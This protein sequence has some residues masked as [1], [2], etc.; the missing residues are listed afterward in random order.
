MTVSCKQFTAIT[1]W[2]IGRPRLRGDGLPTSNLDL[3]NDGG[4]AFT[5]EKRAGS[6]HARRCHSSASH[7]QTS[8]VES[9][10]SPHSGQPGSSINPASKRRTADQRP[11]PTKLRKQDASK[12]GSDLITDAMGFKKGSVGKLGLFAPASLHSASSASLLASH[13]I[14]VGHAIEKF[15]NLPRW[16]RKTPGSTWGTHPSLLAEKKARETGPRV[17]VRG[18]ETRATHVSRQNLIV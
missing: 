17:L 5:A 1:R 10:G 8:W 4:A 11:P 2:G 12:T 3:A 18:G 13:R 14:S 7:A 15:T 16:V 6:F 9:A